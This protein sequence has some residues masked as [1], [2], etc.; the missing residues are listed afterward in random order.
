[1]VMMPSKRKLV[2][3]GVM[4][5]TLE[6]FARINATASF[7]VVLGGTRTSFSI[8]ESVKDRAAA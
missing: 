3:E 5:R 4:H 2:A 1:M 6:P 8:L 7:T